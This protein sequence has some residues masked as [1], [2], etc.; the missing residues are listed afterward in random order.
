MPTP[1]IP[2]VLVLPSIRDLEQAVNQSEKA[3]M[4]SGRDNFGDGGGGLFFWDPQS[5]RRIINQP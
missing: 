3:A 2:E 5:A 4:V 1:P